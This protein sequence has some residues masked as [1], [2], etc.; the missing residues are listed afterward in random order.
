MCPT[1]AA[2]AFQ[3]ACTAW[4]RAI[5]DLRDEA[6]HAAVC[7]TWTPVPENSEAW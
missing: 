2:V 5:T 1:H 4:Q 6:A 7:A 3:A